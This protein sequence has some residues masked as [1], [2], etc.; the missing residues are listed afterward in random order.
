MS[1]AE[2]M[3]AGAKR[4]LAIAKSEFDGAPLT[5]KKRKTQVIGAE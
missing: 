3:R 2:R 5:A 1:L 4:E